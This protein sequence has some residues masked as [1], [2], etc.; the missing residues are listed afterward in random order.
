M[1]RRTL[2]DGENLSHSGRFALAAFLHKA[3]ADAEAIVDAYR[4]APDFDESVTRYQVEHIT[5]K[6]GG[7]GYEPPDCATLRTHG[8]CARDGDPKAREPLG[9]AKDPLCFEEWLRHPLQYLPQEG[10][11]GEPVGGHGPYEGGA[12]RERYDESARRNAVH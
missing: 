11:V 4:G 12:G 6:D 10:R 2:E 3:G 8:L 7:Q 1:M 5:R 9:R